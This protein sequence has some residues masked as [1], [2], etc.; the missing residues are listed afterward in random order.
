M[1]RWFSHIL[2]LFSG[3]SW[4][5]ACSSG[6]G[7][8]GGSIGQ[9]GPVPAAIADL[10]AIAGTD[11]SVTLAWTAPAAAT[12]AA[13][14]LTYELRCTELANAASDPAG[15]HSE[16]FPA[17]AENSSHTM[18][19]LTAGTAYVF[20]LGASYDG[21]EWS[22]PSNLVVA[23]AAGIFDT[24]P[25]ASIR[26]L[27]QWGGSD[28]SVTLAWTAAGD[29]STFGAASSHEVRYALAPI[30]V[31]NWDQATSAA[32][33][34]APAEVAGMLQ[35]TVAGLTPGTDYYFG[36]VATD[37]QGWTS[38]LSNIVSAAAADLTVIRVNVDGSGDYP[39]IERAIGAAQVGDLILVGP[40]RYTWS[41]QG[42]G[43]PLHGMIN[44]PR[45][46]TDFEVRSMAGAAQT[47]LD[48]EGNGAV[49]SVTGGFV[50]EPGGG[51]NYAGITI[52]GFTFTG[53]SAMGQEASTD[54]GWAGGGINVHLSDSIIRN[55]IFRGN[56]ATQ[57]GAVWIGGQGDAVLEDCLIEENSGYIG[58]GVMLINSLPQITVRRCTIR[59]NASTTVGGG[60]FAYHCTMLLEDC[61][62][63]DNHARTSGGGLAAQYMNPGGTIV[64]CTIAGNAGAVR[65]SGVYLSTDTVVR[66]TSSV[67]ALNTGSGGF[68]GIGNSSIE[69]ECSL[70]FG[71]QGGDSLPYGSVDL[72]GNIFS[73]PLFCGSDSYLPG[74]LSPCLPANRPV[75]DGCGVIGFGAPGCAT[76]G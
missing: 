45:D 40:G 71:N 23:T 72:G 9:P 75:G 18:G 52:D 70:V 60:V 34:V 26:D 54:E 16:V 76:G 31:L 29:D 20:S 49:M 1:R 68:S 15:W 73:D 66:L 12:K 62:L 69:L 57:G 50:T 33:A 14:P 47:I 27:R 44:V 36:V 17:A 5:A 11:T 43:D 42:T 53:G 41:A 51:L 19:G 55:C 10:A 2:L 65:G 8:G 22:A 3:L 48:A 63:V 35:I 37:D 58:G 25:P 4:I 6:D 74:P 61:L 7:N 24:T 67:V 59:N 46:W 30:T 28:S 56:E 38:G 39:T 13:N 32:A 64:G 21:V